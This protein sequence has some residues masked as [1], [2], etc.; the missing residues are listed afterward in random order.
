[1]WSKISM[2][3]ICHADSLPMWSVS[4]VDDDGAQ[5]NPQ[6]FLATVLLTARLREAMRRYALIQQI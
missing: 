4:Q 6:L 3:W 2:R 5:T 1:M